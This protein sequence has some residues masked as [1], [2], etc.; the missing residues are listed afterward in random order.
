MCMSVKEMSGRP[1]GHIL[2]L[3]RSSNLRTQV[4]CALF[5]VGGLAKGSGSSGRVSAGC[6][7]AVV[8]LPDAAPTLPVRTQAPWP[9]RDPLQGFF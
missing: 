6:L 3:Y 9:R 5:L 8:Q 7:A 1:D 2:G 4:Q